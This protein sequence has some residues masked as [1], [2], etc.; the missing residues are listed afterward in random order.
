MVGSS[1]PCTEQ[2][3]P[4]RR[5]PWGTM[6]T[7]VA[8]TVSAPRDHVL[9]LFLDYTQWPRIFHETISSTEL[10][11]R[12]S[13]SLLV[14]VEHRREGRVL[15]VL[16]DCGDGVV[17]LREFKRR[18]NATFVN[19]FARVQDGTRYTVDAEVRIKPPFTLI[20]PFLRGV[21]ERAVRRYTIEPL[22]EAAE[23]ARVGRE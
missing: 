1:S 14:M 21:V 22:R 20:A 8:A 12:E 10:V 13:H 3:D 5:V 17:A 4:S 19:R 15:N 16:T 11:R 9:A 7:T 18:F 6:Q 2:R 23:S